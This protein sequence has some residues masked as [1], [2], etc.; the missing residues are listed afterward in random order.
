[1][2]L[3]FIETFLNFLSMIKRLTTLL[4][5]IIKLEKQKYPLITRKFKAMISIAW[6]KI[7][8]L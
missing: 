8:K 2:I 4:L 6:K 3:K 7:R 1:M 5:I